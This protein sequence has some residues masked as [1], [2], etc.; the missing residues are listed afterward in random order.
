MLDLDRDAFDVIRSLPPSRQAEIT[1]IL[2]GT[3]N[4][5]KAEAHRR[6]NRSLVAVRPAV[7]RNPM[8]TETHS[9]PR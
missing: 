8:P 3:G 2:R 7:G 6:L 1:N 5:T 9:L 4:V